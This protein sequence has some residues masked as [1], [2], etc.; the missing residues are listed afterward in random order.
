LALDT[1]LTGLAQL[2]AF[3]LDCRR[4]F[5]SLI[6]HENQYIIAEATKTVSLETGANHGSEDDAIFLGATTIDLLFGVCPDTMTMFTAPAGSKSIDSDLVHANHNYYVMND[7]SKI[8]GY[9]CRPYVSG[10]PHM[11]YYAE[12]PI[13]SPSGLTIGS[14]CVVDNKPRA[15]VDMLGVESLQEIANCVMDHLELVMSKV[16][17]RRA[18]RMIQG[19]GL[20]I[21]GNCSLRDWWVETQ[22]AS[23]LIRRPRRRRMTL[24]EQADVEFGPRS[25][26]TTDLQ[27]MSFDSLDK[28]FAGSGAGSVQSLDG[29]NVFFRRSSVD[30]ATPA[31]TIHSPKSFA[32][33]SP[34]SPSLDS[35]TAKLREAS[36][37]DAIT[38][39]ASSANTTIPETAG[40][41]S[42]RPSVSSVGTTSTSNNVSQCGNKKC[43]KH[44]EMLSRAANLIREAVGLEGVVFLDPRLGNGRHQVLQDDSVQEIRKLSGFKPD[45][46]VTA[47]AAEG[48]VRRG[49][50]QIEPGVLCKVLAC[51]TRDCYGLGK[52]CC[53]PFLLKEDILHRLIQKFPRGCVMK[54]DVDGLVST[55]ALDLAFYKHIPKAQDHV[56]TITR[57][58]KSA[59]PTMKGTF[60]ADELRQI[61]P[62]VH[63]VILFPLWD[64]SR[65]KL[66]AY[67]I[68]WTSD[69]NR[70]F[71]REEFAYLASFSNS[72]MAELSRLDT[73]AADR[74][75]ADFISSISHELRSPLHGILASAELLKSI[76]PDATAVEIINTIETCGSTLLDTMENLLAFTKINNLTVTQNEKKAAPVE[77]GGPTQAVVPPLK[78]LT[79]DV[80]LAL[81]VEEVMN[82]KVSGHQFLKSFEQ[83]A[84]YKSRQDSPTSIASTSSE[85]PDSVTVVCDIDAC[86]NWSF[87]TQPGAWKRIVM[88]LFGNSLKYTQDGF[89]HVRLLQGERP[90]HKSDHSLILVCLIVEDS[91]KGISEDYLRHRL[92][93]PFQQEDPL[94]PGTGL[95]LS[96]VNQLVKSIGG[97][98]EIVS[99]VGSGTKVTITA[100]LEELPRSATSIPQPLISEQASSQLSGRQIGLF[101]LDAYPDIRDTPTGILSP[102][103]KRSLL[104]KASLARSIKNT[105]GLDVVTVKPQDAERHVLDILI[106]HEAEFRSR[107]LA[108]KRPKGVPLIVLSDQ[109]TLD[110]RPVAHQNGPV[111]FLSQ[112][113][114]PRLVAKALESC[115][116]F[117]TADKNNF[118]LTHQNSI[119]EN[120][121]SPDLP[122]QTPP[123]VMAE[124][125]ESPFSPSCS[126]PAPLAANPVRPRAAKVNNGNGPRALLVEDNPINLK[127]LTTFMA[128][129]KHPYLTA[130][131]GLEAVAAYK[132]AASSIDIILMDIQM[133]NMDGMQAS[134]EIRKFE[135]ASGLGRRVTIV[136]LT[137]LASADAQEMAMLSGIDLFLTK[138]V[139]LRS[140]RVLMEERAAEMAR[141]AEGLEAK[142]GEMAAGKVDA[143]L[144]TVENQRPKLLGDSRPNREKSVLGGNVVTSPGEVRD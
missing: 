98:I 123:I 1:T 134:Y 96:I 113:F 41:E 14:I 43:S 3:K 142:S 126:V 137:G 44:E 23:R 39:V 5:I 91:G 89:I 109:L 80:D 20:F 103:L 18:E 139:P 81:L 40:K 7:L 106:T 110:Y 129:L 35:V 107:N 19:L 34:V 29:D 111:I 97:S 143:P 55:N 74:A 140:L 116:P 62:D 65:G 83:H 118:K 42:P 56:K 131:D 47:D 4:S 114:G 15:G 22:K 27:E 112:P 78:S 77:G 117:F 33:P 38:P 122:L 90:V 88:N 49:S 63:S 45:P 16:Q 57:E 54:F 64:S 120:L 75:K 10:W 13:H 94:C 105:F 128:K 53:A 68:A 69:P 36:I 31:E 58:D 66:F 67:N 82:T 135:Q 84:S 76:G 141:A 130:T 46:Q 99:E 59:L 119:F 17:R 51:S 73:I 52:S 108:T 133:P 121:P 30:S 2:A 115:V 101:D 86:L 87:K 136:A 127:L 50:I 144:A 6:D 100:L 25:S 9:E 60:E 12:V 93:T 32:S 61:F 72:I 138:P 37:F 132:S 70:S 125:V 102:S 11:R 79:S 92:F 8:P 124:I 95:G 21:D 85:M 104:I 24:D 48:P 71:E 28:A 26:E